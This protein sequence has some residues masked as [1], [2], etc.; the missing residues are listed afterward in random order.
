MSTV[1]NPEQTGV[2]IWSASFFCFLLVTVTPGPEVDGKAEKG[3]GREAEGWVEEWPV[4]WL[5]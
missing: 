3:W 1:T 2:A 5:L 4:P